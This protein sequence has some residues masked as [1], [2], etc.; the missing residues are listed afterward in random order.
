MF[1]PSEDFIYRNI[2]N[3]LEKKIA[4]GVLML[5]DKLPSVR[6]ISSEHG[7]SISTVLQ[8]YYLLESKSLI[9][10]K[11]KSGYF[12]TYSPKGFPDPVTPSRPAQTASPNLT[13]DVIS[14][15]Y[16]QIGRKENLALS[17]S[18]PAMELLPVAKLNK[19][20]TQA[21]RSLEDSGTSYEIVEG[22][23][24]L[25]RQIARYAYT[26]G[27]NLNEDDIVIT[28]GA[29]G[30]LTYCLSALVK[31]GDTIAVESPVYFGILQLAQGLGLNVLE[32]P[33]CADTGI[34]TVAL[35]N[36]LKEGRIQVCLLV[37]NFSNPLG[38]CMPDSHKK[39][40]VELLDFYGVPLVEDDPYG[41]V[42]FGSHRPKSCKSFDRTG[43]VLWCG[44]F[45]KTLA[46]G[47]RIGWVAPGKYKE[48]IIK[49]KSYQTIAT[50][51][52][53]QEAIASFLDSGRY[54][55]HLRK[56]R[57][58]L[59]ANSLHFLRAIAEYF[60][61]DTKVTR[62]QG[63]FIL[64]L[65]LNEKV[66]GLGLYEEAL[67]HRICIAPGRMFTLQD[68]YHNCIRLSYGMGWS[69]TVETGLRTLGKIVR[70]W[71]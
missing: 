45:S 31:R 2:A 23:P 58:V 34:D 41:D 61:P 46:A 43:N 13:E 15:V 56:L 35:E 50:P 21:M 8:A 59:H 37:S 57:S 33:T 24:K 18:V 26:W 36:H 1:Q 47:Y 52:L 53:Q 54:E 65:E 11:P 30:A 32:L 10:S 55:S 6:T 14:R 19:A 70:D 20:M 12:V 63:G 4:D 3:N 29:M 22:N 25:R 17:L 42:Y 51:T 71:R 68:Q 62:P 9:R 67:R 7:V 38:S 69:E 66:D 39:T 44:S 64:W 60:P 40:V 5:G 49:A 27:G 28:P 16:S 48:K